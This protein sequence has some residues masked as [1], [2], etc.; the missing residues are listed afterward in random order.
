LSCQTGFVPPN[1]IT[2][3]GS[4]RRNEAATATNAGLI[5][6]DTF[7]QNQFAEILTS[8]YAC[9]HIRWKRND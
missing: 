3:R 6:I 5:I 2:F 8:H 7:I 1:R 4:V 9:S